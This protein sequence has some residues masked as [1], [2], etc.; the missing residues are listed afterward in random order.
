M[1]K[2]VFTKKTVVIISVVLLI[3]SSTVTILMFTVF[4]EYETHNCIEITSNDDVSNYNFLGDGSDENPFLIEGLK[5]KSDE[6]F[7]IKIYNTTYS[8][9]VRNCYF[10]NE[11]FCCLRLWEQNSGSIIVEDNIF[12]IDSEK[13]KHSFGMTAQDSCNITIRKNKFLGYST[14]S[15]IGLYLWNCSDTLI[16]EN[17]FESTDVSLIYAQNLMFNNNKF[18]GEEDAYSSLFSHDVTN[19]TISHTIS[20]KAYFSLSLGGCRSIK[21]LKNSLNTGSIV[22]RND[23]I[24]DYFEHQVENNFIAE[25]EYGFFVNLTD[26]IIFEEYSMINL[27]QSDNVTISN[28][29]QFDIST[30]IQLESCSNCTIMNNSVAD[31]RSDSISVYNS[32]YTS[33]IDNQI[34]RSGSESIFISSSPNTTIMDCSIWDNYANGGY[35][36]YVFTNTRSL[37]IVDSPDSTIENNNITSERCSLEIR[38]SAYS[39]I[40]SNRFTSIDIG[41]LMKDK[42]IFYTLNIENNTVN[43]KKLGI[44]VNQVNFSISPEYNQLIVI[45]CSDISLENRFFDLF[46]SNAIMFYNSSNISISFSSFNSIENSRHSALSFRNCSNVQFHYVLIDNSYTGLYCWNCSNFTFSFLTVRNSDSE[47]VDCYNGVNFLFEYCVFKSCRDAIFLVASQNIHISSILCESSTINI[48]NCD[49]IT[50]QNSE[51]KECEGCIGLDDSSRIDILNN[52]FEYELYAI[53]FHNYYTVTLYLN[54]INNT[55]TGGIIGIILN[56]IT[57]PTLIERNAIFGNSEEEIWEFH[58]GI[59][60]HHCEFLTITNNYIGYNSRGV[61]LESSSYSTITF[62][63]FEKNI[64]Y[65]IR[66]SKFSHDNFIYQNNFFENHIDGEFQAYDDGEDNDWNSIG[67]IG[68]YWSNCLDQ[69]NCR[70]EGEGWSFDYH[71]LVEPVEIPYNSSYFNITI[72]DSSYIPAIIISICSIF[73]IRVLKRR[74]RPRR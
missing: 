59:Y 35:E 40:L 9:I 52:S 24:E 48:M 21:I 62:N 46:N 15:Q 71:P 63:I 14:S 36:G 57:S 10:T 29:N 7:D 69:D 56:S 61:F 51:F 38:E 11:E 32:N 27:I 13:N 6:N 68:N 31:S 3:L 12:K 17:Y 20:N 55:L 19:I 22:I 47:G 23:V 25:R 28:Q 50:I 54:I 30:G 18:D 73:A 16:Q 43:E 66:L 74:K 26:Q 42:D 70:I 44:F 64:N 1:L 33:I 60:A 37:K 39:S 53:S 4:T 34:L 41:N 45:N 49:N 2:S 8:Y 72:S 5:F 67:L 65:A 58:G